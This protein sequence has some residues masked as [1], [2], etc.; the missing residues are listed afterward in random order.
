[1]IKCYDCKY[2]IDSN[3]VNYWDL[4]PKTQYDEGVPDEI[5]NR[6]DERHLRCKA[7]PESIPRDTFYRQNA[8]KDIWEQQCN[9]GYSYS[10]GYYDEEADRYWES[11]Y[12]E[13]HEVINK[14]YAEGGT[15]MFWW[16][17]CAKSFHPITGFEG[18]RHNVEH[19]LV[20]YR[21]FYR[22]HVYLFGIKLP[23]PVITDDM[24]ENGDWQVYTWDD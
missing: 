24:L 13:L 14:Y 2:F 22:G 7:F 15:P 9:N 8:D 17:H 10:P 3:K 18:I 1:M 16:A 12:Q 11:R 5:V 19:N 6:L 23:E 20:I 4:F 21:C